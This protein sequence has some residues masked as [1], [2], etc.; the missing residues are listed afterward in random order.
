MFA[1]V[2]LA[3]CSGIA[4]HGRTSN[5]A[6]FTETD[7]SGHQV[8]QLSFI[9]TNEPAQTCIAGDWKK[10]EV[11]EGAAGYT[12]NP[13]YTLENGRLEVLLVNQVCDSY[14]SYVGK[15]SNGQFHGEHVAYGLGFSKTLGKV[16]GAYANK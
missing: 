10:A 12:H 13:A 9:F 8:R 16:S 3:G 11:I 4:T 2:A 7:S 1:A 14:D 15:L 5:L 6:S